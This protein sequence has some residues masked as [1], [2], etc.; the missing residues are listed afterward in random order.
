MADAV[1]IEHTLIS[2]VYYSY[3]HGCVVCTTVNIAVKIEEMESSGVH[4]LVVL[5]IFF[6]YKNICS[7]EA[8]SQFRI[9]SVLVCCD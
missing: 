1:K 6:I 8:N 7:H 9:Y 3:S 4:W 2:D 5:L